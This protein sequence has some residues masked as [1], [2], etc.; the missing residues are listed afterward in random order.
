MKYVIVCA[1]ALAVFAA[2]LFFVSRK[3]KFD[4]YGQKLR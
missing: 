1:I 3:E 2:V 4:G